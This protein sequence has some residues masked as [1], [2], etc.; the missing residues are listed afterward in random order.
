MHDCSIAITDLE[1]RLRVGI[2]DHEREFQPIRINLNL[3]VAALLPEERF[4]GHDSIVTWIT[5]EWP[6]S[7]HT[8][9]IETRLRELMQF[10]FE[11]DTRIDWIDVAISKPTAFP[12]VGGVGVRMAISRCDHAAW[13]G[14]SGITSVM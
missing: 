3:S 6:K 2:W 1:T 14:A 7:Q 12:E 11:F 4:P 8:P 10:V 5:D 13:F 9:L